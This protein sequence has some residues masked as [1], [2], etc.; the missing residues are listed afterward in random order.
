MPLFGGLVLSEVLNL[1]SVPMEYIPML[2][3][4]RVGEGEDPK[5][6]V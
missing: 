6:I 1:L 4:D 2:F 5:E 3:P